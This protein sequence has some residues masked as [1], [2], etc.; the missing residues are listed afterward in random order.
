MGTFAR[1]EQSMPKP[2]GEEEQQLLAYFFQ[3]PRPQDI[4]D[5]PEGE[6]LAAEWAAY[7][8]E[9]A[10][11]LAEGHQGRF[12]LVRGDHVHS[13]WDTERDA[14]Q[15]GRTLFGQEPFM[16]HQIRPVERPAKF[17]YYRRWTS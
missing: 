10:R 8:R 3:S 4:P 6:L 7:K 2:I 13:V 17:G 16:V 15:A 14:L 11:L 5:L 1:E 12:A 9:V